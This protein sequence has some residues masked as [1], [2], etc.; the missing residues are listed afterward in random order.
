MV[1]LYGPGWMEV[2]APT[3]FQGENSSH[4]LAALCVTEALS[5]SLHV[6]KDPVYLLLLNAVSAFDLVVIEH[7][8][9]SAWE[10]GTIDE[11]LLYLAN[12]LRYNSL[13]WSGRSRSWVPLQTPWAWSREGAPVTDCI[14]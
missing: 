9:R 6:N 13:L 4:E 2:Q 10:A 11:G 8:I 5:H 1:D 3:P 12:R 14:V 7:A